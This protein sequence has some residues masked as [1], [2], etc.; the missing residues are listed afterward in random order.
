MIE[1]LSFSQTEKE[2]EERYITFMREI[3]ETGTSL[4]PKALEANLL[5]LEVAY[6]RRK[7]EC[8]ERQQDSKA[9]HCNGCFSNQG[10]K[11]SALKER[12]N[13]ELNETCQEQCSQ[14]SKL[15]TF[16]SAAKNV[17]S[18]QGEQDSKKSL[19]VPYLTLR[20][21]EASV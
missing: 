4:D 15:Y 17:T 12:S 20:E 14:K 5:K 9:S 13:Y 11:R 2:A 10:R 1:E 19:L 8:S 18:F 3:K 7:L 21:D 6:L 16:H